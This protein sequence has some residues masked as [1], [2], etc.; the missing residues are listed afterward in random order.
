[1]LVVC[2]RCKQTYEVYTRVT[3]PY[4]C[5]S[6]QATGG[7]SVA[8]W[9]VVR[10]Y[11]DPYEDVQSM[12]TKARSIDKAVD[13]AIDTYGRQGIIIRPEG[14]YLDTGPVY[15]RRVGRPRKPVMYRRRRANERA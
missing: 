5:I 4:V 12:L 7:D 14:A 3:N 9:Y 8:N 11:V 15:K 1:M 2:T 6:C 10:F 13:Q